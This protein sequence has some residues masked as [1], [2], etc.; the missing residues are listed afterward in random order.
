MYKKLTTKAA[1]FDLDGTL[2]DSKWRF[3]SAFN[4][5]L[6]KFGLNQ[7][8]KKFFLKLYHANRLNELLFPTNEDKEEKLVEFWI[9]FLKIYQKRPTK[10]D[11]LIPGAYRVL[12]ELAKRRIPVAIVT[13]RISSQREIR[14]ELSRFKIEQFVKVVVAKKNI[15][16]LKR[17]ESYIERTDEIKEAAK[18]LNTP[19]QDCIV[20]GDYVSDIRSGKAS[21]AKTV[22]VLSGASSYKILAEEKPDLILRS[23]ADL[24]DNVCFELSQREVP[25]REG[26]DEGYTRES[27]S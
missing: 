21:G 15:P 3:Y 2:I 17:V 8:N 13:G 20:V 16:A 4:E 18:M 6:S 12:S 1:I 11:R 10:S 23:V 22:A 24:L 9:T 19:V 25:I 5:T 7:V 26:E 14:E 27:C